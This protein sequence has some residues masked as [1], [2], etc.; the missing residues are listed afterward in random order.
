MSMRFKDAKKVR[1]FDIT[2][3]KKG[4][5]SSYIEDGNTVN[6]YFQ[7]KQI[8][9]IIHHK[10]SGVEIVGYDTNRRV[11]YNDEVGQSE[12]LFNALHN[13]MVTWMASNLN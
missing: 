10:G 8:H 1:Q 2:T 12:I 7:F 3:Y 11:F 4:F 6:E 13:T 5:T 9:E